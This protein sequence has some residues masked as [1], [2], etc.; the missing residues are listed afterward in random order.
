MASL[1]T[2]L[3]AAAADRRP[4]RAARPTL[5]VAALEGR[6]LLSVGVGGMAYPLA[7][8]HVAEVSAAAG[9]RES[10]SGTAHKR[11][12]FYES[13]TGPKNRDLNVVSATVTLVPGRRL[14]LTGVMEGNIVK[15]PTTSAQ[16]S[17][18]VFGIDR[19]S[20]S[21]VTPFFRRPGVK[22]DA[23]VVVSVEQEGIKAS[24]TDLATHTTTAL[25]PKAVHISGR[26]VTVTVDPA[27]LPTP[28]GGVALSQSRFNLWPRSDL[29]NV[30]QLNHG[31]FVASFVPEDATARIGVRH[32]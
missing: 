20:P 17:Y 12:A 15:K 13:Y 19:L 22:F 28:A 16:E 25:D 30:L 4:R 5:S 9:N 11:P 26:S 2:R 21:A 24:V 18:Y 7:T 1:R 14:T 6:A 8:H 10:T 23:V 32:S 3:A 27:L 29:S 31:S